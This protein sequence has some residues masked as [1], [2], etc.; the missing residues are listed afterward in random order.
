MEGIMAMSEKRGSKETYA[1][2]VSL[3]IRMDWRKVRMRTGTDDRL[4]HVLLKKGRAC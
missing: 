1:P 2:K 4:I 3:N